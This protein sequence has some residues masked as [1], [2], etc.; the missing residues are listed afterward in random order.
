MEKGKLFS[1]DPK[2]LDI[3]MPIVTPR[4][5]IHVAD[6]TMAQDY[7]DA[8]QEAWDSLS[9]WMP[10][11]TEDEKKRPISATAS[12][13]RSAHAQFLNRESLMMAAYDRASGQ[14]CGSTGLQDID[15]T[16]RS[17]EIGYW[18]RQSF[19]GQGRA[20]ELG[21]ALARYAFAALQAQCVTTGHAEGNDASRR[22]IEKLG[23]DKIGVR[24][25]G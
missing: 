3:P 11:A 21:N 8:K 7:Y 24:P 9:Q 14:F 19:Q 25:F 2:T 22:T 6:E 1:D 13:L 10:W 5:I 15:W 12:F 18:I 4:M 17:M 20:G 23:F 16:V